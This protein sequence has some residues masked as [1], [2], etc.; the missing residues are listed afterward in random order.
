MAT[1][2]VVDPWE[3]VDAHIDSCVL[4]VLVEKHMNVNEREVLFFMTQDLLG[5]PEEWKGENW[6]L[7]HRL[8]LEGR[9]PPWRWKAVVDLYRGAVHKLIRLD[10]IPR[11]QMRELTGLDFDK[12]V[13]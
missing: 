12:Y 6:R 13:P 2:D 4:M 7:L 1:E 8:H 5:R 11:T 3:Q 9:G 10:F